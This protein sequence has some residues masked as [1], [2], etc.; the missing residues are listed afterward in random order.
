M[1]T[2]CIA[3]KNNIA[4]YGAEYLLKQYPD[5]KLMCLVNGNDAGYDTW[6]SSLKKFCTDN[7]VP[8][9]SLEECYEINDL[10]FISLEYDRII[11]PHR[12]KTHQLYNI[13]FSKLPSYKGMY[14]SALPL[15]FGDKES[16]V[17]LHKIDSGIDTGEIIDQM[18]FSLEQ[19]M[20]SRILYD[21][22]IKHAQALFEKNISSVL[23]N[24]V[25]SYSQPCL[26]Y[27]SPSPRDA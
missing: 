4:V 9:I 20:S 19:V 1:Q 2:V 16:G 17:T 6:Q 27:T 13:H 8:I 18:T 5:I 10:I 25:T 11:R 26:L 12:F 21:L 15:L 23:S 3:G 22:Y 24:N 7:D 14:T